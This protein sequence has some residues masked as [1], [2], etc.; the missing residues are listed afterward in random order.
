VEWRNAKKTAR[1]DGWLCVSRPQPIRGRATLFQKDGDFEAFE[2]VL[3]EGLDWQ[4][5]RVLAY[6]IMPNYWHLVLWPRRDGELSEYL[7]WVTVTHTQRF[8]AHYHT[9]GTGP[10]Y[11]GRFKAFPVQSNEH[12]LKLCR[13]VERNA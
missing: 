13:Y 2:R 3:Q 4:P 9:S 7:R 5:M 1:R 8:H 10:A 11:Q 6:C 12:L